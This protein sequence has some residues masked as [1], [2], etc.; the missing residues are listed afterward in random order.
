MLTKK[1]PPFWSDY[2]NHLKQKKKDL[3]L[4]ELSSHMRTEETNRL[5]DKMSSLSL[6]FVNFNLVESTVPMNKD[7]FKGKGK[8]L[9]K[10][11]S[12]KILSLSNVLFVPSLRRNLVSNTLL[13]IASLKIVQKAS[14]VVHVKWD[15]VGKGCRRGLYLS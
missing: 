7:R 2:K 5:K 11:T 1:F 12:R 9:L 13:G 15:F 10:F 6:N 3:T 14:K 8:A 4:Q